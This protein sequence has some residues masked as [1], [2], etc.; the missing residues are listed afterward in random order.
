MG[1]SRARGHRPQLLTTTRG[2]AENKH[3][4]CRWMHPWFLA[5]GRPEGEGVTRLDIRGHEVRHHPRIGGGP[6]EVQ[7]RREL[8]C[9]SLGAMSHSPPTPHCCRLSCRAMVALDPPSPLTWS[10]PVRWLPAYWPPIVDNDALAV[11][12]QEVPPAGSQGPPA[13]PLARW[14]GLGRQ[15]L[16]LHGAHPSKGPP[17]G[18]L[19]IGHWRG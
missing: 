4:Y 10:R 17:H 6:G 13:A 3:G 18:G 14:M 19:L 8:P 15:I 2:V 1:R 11:A 12:A 7:R 16:G 9:P 5:T